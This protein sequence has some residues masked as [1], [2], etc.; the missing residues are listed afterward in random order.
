MDVQGSPPD[1]T[2]QDHG[3]EHQEP[4]MLRLGPLRGERV[5]R[6]LG[7]WQRRE[8]RLA[9]SFPACGDLGR[10]QLED[11]YQETTIA[12]LGLSF[13]NEKHL[14]RALHWGIT[15]RALQVHR[16]E[17]R[18]G[19]LLDEHG[20]ELELAAHA[21]EEEQTP[22]LAT[23]LAQDRL[24]VAEFLT[25]LTGLE[26][27]VFW[28]MA[29]G[30]RYRAI[31][32]LLGIPVNEAR[33]ASRSC[34]RKRA[35]FQLLYDTGRLCGYRAHTIRALKAGQSA[36]EQLTLGAYAHL[37]FCSRCRSEH[38]TNARRLRRSFSGQAA[39]L[40][41]IPVLTGRLGWLGRVS[42]RL[43]GV[44]HRALPYAPPPGGSGAREGAIALLASGAG[45]AKLAAAGASIAVLAGGTL[46]VTHVLEGGSHTSRSNHRASSR[47]RS[48][49]PAVTPAVPA[50]AAVPGGPAT[51]VSGRGSSVHEH[52]GGSSEPGGFAYL[53][54]PGGR[55]ESRATPA[56]TAATQQPSAP[57]PQGGASRGSSGGGP[58]SP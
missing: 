35:R 7:E 22:E 53:G 55:G 8:V 24:I 45:A 3:A 23:L 14:R 51:D 17:D 29:E 34:E 15:H 19:E 37:E 44:A 27:S 36:S 58:F 12:L 38:R 56:R 48:S 40:L 54:V 41:P 50:G 43:R 4:A 13:Q 52:G 28:M 5:G 47:A 9:R 42:E 16:N 6:M 21:R 31:A 1:P 46:G 30:M 49:R 10:E 18:R 20:P 32:P 11:I 57:A 39:A 25:E 33:K 26:R 2:P